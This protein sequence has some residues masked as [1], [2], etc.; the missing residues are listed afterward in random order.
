MLS[1]VKLIFYIFSFPSKITDKTDK[2]T[3]DRD[4]I[5]TVI[6]PQTQPERQKLDTREGCNDKET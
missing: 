1:Y 2:S 5:E 6:Q 3:H 4:A